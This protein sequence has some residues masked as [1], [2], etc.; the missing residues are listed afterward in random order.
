MLQGTKG[1]FRGMS[2]TFAREIPGNFAFFGGYELTRSLLTPE[3]GSVDD[4]STGKLLFAGGMGGAGFWAA[5]YPFDVVKTRIQV[6]GSSLSFRAMMFKIVKQEGP[7]ALV[8][9]IS[10]TIIRAFPSNAALFAS[11]EVSRKMMEGR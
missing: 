7:Q 11:Y 2:S 10:P 4:L 6:E 3:G 1:L 8:R 9:G 5:S